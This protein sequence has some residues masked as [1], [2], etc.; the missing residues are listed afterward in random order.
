VHDHCNQNLAL[1]TGW[2]KP[3]NEDH[4]AAIDPSSIINN[5]YI[6]R[7]KGKKNIKKN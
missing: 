6:G 2:L 5:Y 1:H 3:D 7:S 4:V